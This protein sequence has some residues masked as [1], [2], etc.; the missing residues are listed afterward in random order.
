MR[1]LKVFWW[2]RG[3]Q[4]GNFGDELS[5][6]LVEKL[7]GCRVVWSSLAEADLVAIGSLLEPH[8]ARPVEW[9]KF[10]GTI[11]GSGRMYDGEALDLSAVAVAALRGKLSLQRVAVSDPGALALGDPGLLV[12]ELADRAVPTTLLGVV[13]HWSERRHPFFRSPLCQ[14][15]GVEVIDPC[16]PLEVV[17]AKLRCCRHILASALHGL[18][19]G[20]AYG[21]PNRW[22][23]LQTGR[24]AV[25][26][27][28]EFK[29]RDYYSAFDR[30]LPAPLSLSGS[31]PLGAVLSAFAEYRPP[32]VE[33][34][35]RRLLAT[36]PFP[37]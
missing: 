23:R 28:P 35:R 10:A 37:R 7:S 12:S 33:P 21:I 31:E 15:P 26:G 3:P 32:Q 2:Q 25:A 34:I 22:L 4:F 8:L 13:P 19:V 5:R 27:Y 24:E 6:A 16:A 36:F 9:S 29:Y 1:V 11:W 20:D 14:A 18:I 30:A 17:L